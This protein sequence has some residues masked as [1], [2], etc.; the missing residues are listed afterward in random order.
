VA[1]QRAR[2]RRRR[3]PAFLWLPPS[4]KAAALRLSALLMLADALGDLPASALQLT[5]EGPATTIRVAHLPAALAEGAAPIERWQK[6]I[7]PLRIELTS[8]PDFETV[9]D[10]IVPWTL[11]APWAAVVVPLR[12]DAAEPLAEGV[13]RILRHQLE[14]LLAREAAVR[15]GEDAEDVH[16]LRV[17]TRRLRASLQVVASCFEPQIIRH[18]RR[19]L[20]AVATAL[21]AVRDRDV[22]REHLAHYQESLPAPARDELASL[23]AAVEQDYVG[24]RQTMLA[25]LETARYTRFKHAFAAFLTTPG[26]GV[27][28]LPETGVPLRVQDLAGSLLW[29]RYEALR[30]FGPVLLTDSEEVQHQARIVGKRLRYTI[31]CFAEAIT[32]RISG[33]S[34]APAVALLEPL[35][36]LQEALG[37][38]QDEVA[39]RAYLAELHLADDPGAQAYLAHRRAERAAHLA[40]LPACWAQVVGA[41]YRR[42]LLEVLDGL[43]PAGATP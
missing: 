7:G 28:R 2:L 34:G 38:L 24:A 31:E 3:E 43:S 33:A 18:F 12:L 26:A 6:A 42:Q 22:F 4:A 30:A 29:R 19:G 23:L 20:R 10:T 41:P 25:S 5:C 8:P 40:A 21:G 11:P 13:R 14:R 17:A 36:S 1:F 27:A 39:A 32:P 15:S 9:P 35:A 16:Q 37:A